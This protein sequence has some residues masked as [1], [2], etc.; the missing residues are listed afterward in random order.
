A[1]VV[2]Y[3]DFTNK[4]CSD[5]LKDISQIV[6]GL[7]HVDDDSIGRFVARDLYNPGEV[8]DISDRIKTRLETLIWDQTTQFVEVDGP[9]DSAVSGDN[10]FAASG[11]TI[12]S[13]FTPNEAFAQSLASSYADFYSKGR[14]NVEATVFDSDGHIYQPLDRVLLDGFRYIVYESDHDLANDEVRLS[15]LEDI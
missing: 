11:L 8:L 15:L 1:G 9:N 5:G 3:A 2:S 4:S 12:D 6:N 7:F 10:S 13:Q 14:K